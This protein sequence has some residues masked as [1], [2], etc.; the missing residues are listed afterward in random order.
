MGKESNKGSGELLVCLHSLGHNVSH[1][2]LR[3]GT[4]DSIKSN[5]QAV[6]LA[7][8]SC[9]RTRNDK[10]GAKSEGEGED[11][12]RQTHL[13]VKRLVTVFFSPILFF[14]FLLLL[15]PQFGHEVGL[16]YIPCTNR[17]VLSLDW[18]I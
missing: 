11:Y 14:S 10:D 12:C 18:V 6:A 4:S 9:L 16:P 1:N 2:L 5:M 3:I 13:H 15:P 7:F 17:V 8:L